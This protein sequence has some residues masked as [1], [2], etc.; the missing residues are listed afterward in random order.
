M[1][2]VACPLVIS[3][4]FSDTSK[5]MITQIT[6]VKPSG[7]QGRRKRNEFETGICQ[8][9]WKMT[10]SEGRTKANKLQG[11]Q[12]FIMYVHAIVIEQV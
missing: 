5:P 6:L 10:G 11:R 9:E 12:A 1:S 3:L 4:C 7:P 8:E 2:S